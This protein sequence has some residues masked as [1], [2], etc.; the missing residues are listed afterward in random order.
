MSIQL[1]YFQLL[2]ILA[3]ILFMGVSKTTY[4]YKHINLL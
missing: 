4:S 2:D 3:F 1:T